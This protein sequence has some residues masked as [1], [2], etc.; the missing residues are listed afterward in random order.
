MRVDLSEKKIF[1]FS[2]FIELLMNSFNSFFGKDSAVFCAAYPNVSPT[3]TSSGSTFS[4][5]TTPIFTY[6]YE[7]VPCMMGSIEKNQEIKPRRRGSETIIGD[8]G[9]EVLVEI[10]AQRFTYTLTF[11]LWAEN[12]EEA[13]KYSERFQEFMNSYIPYFIDCGC[14]NIIFLKLNADQNEKQW[15]S[16][17]IRREFKYRLD[18]DELTN[19][20][21]TD[22]KSILVNFKPTFSYSYQIIDKE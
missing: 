4:Q 1:K 9:N 2:S 3:A 16:D 12:G 17:L 5:L 13:E 7:K 11:E 22:I 18:L 21:R 8:D 19:I 14:E 6:K 20:Q 10:Y 15:R